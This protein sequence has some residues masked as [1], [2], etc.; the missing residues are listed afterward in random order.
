MGS[1][2]SARSSEA[3]LRLLAVQLAKLVLELGERTADLDAGGDLLDR[4]GQD[5]RRRQAPARPPGGQLPVDPAYTIG[6]S[7]IH[8]W[9][10]EHI[11]Q[12]SPEV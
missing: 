3:T 4:Q 7:P 9:A 10:A 2:E 8:A 11:G 5:R 1:D 6:P 12:C